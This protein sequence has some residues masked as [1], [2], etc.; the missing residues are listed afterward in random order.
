MA[1]QVL[2]HTATSWITSALGALQT[3]PS[4]QW[5]RWTAVILGIIIGQGL[6]Y[7]PSLLGSK[8]L[9]PLDILA[10]P[11]M[12]IPRTPVVA[13]IPE[14]DWSTGDLITQ[15]EPA[16]RYFASELR[17]G[18][19][20]GWANYHFAGAPF[21]WPRFSVFAL[22]NCLDESPRVLAWTQLIV[23]LVAGLGAYGFCREV[24]RL[25]FWPATMCGWCYPLTG[26]LVLWQGMWLGTSTV[27]WLP[28]LLLFVHQAI[29]NSERWKVPLGLIAV[30]FVTVTS[31]Q[32]DV[33]AQVMAISGLF[34]LWLVWHRK[35]AIILPSGKDKDG[36]ETTGPG[37]PR[38]EP[39]ASYVRP[40][41]FLSGGWALGLLLAAPY[42]L[43]F[44]EYAKTGYRIERRAQG[45]EERP[46]VGLA[47]L[48]QLVLPDYYGRSTYGSV[49]TI[50][51]VPQESAAGAYA[52]VVAMLVLSPVAWGSRRLRPITGFLWLLGLI[53]LS[54][55]LDLPV[56]VDAMRLPG[57]NLVSYNRLVFA[58]AFA[59]TVLA[60][61][62]LEVMSRADI[63]W[64]RWYW[65]GCVPILVAASACVYRW[66]APP[67]GIGPGLESL[68]QQGMTVSWIKDSAD[69]EQVRNWFAQH[70][71]VSAG[72][73]ILGIG[74]WLAFSFRRSWLHRAVP[75]LTIVLMG[76][77][78]WFAYGRASQS[79]WGLYYPRIE[80]LEQIKQAASGRVIGYHCLPATTAYMA[81]LQDIRGYD[82]VDP[83]RLIELLAQTADPKS[84]I[85]SYAYSQMLSPKVSVD[86]AGQMKLSPILDFLGV[87]YVIAREPFTN[88]LTT[89]FQS[90]DYYV[91]ENHRALPRVYVPGRFETEADPSLRLR[92]LTSE[93]FDPR[94]LVI[95]E[96][97][98]ELPETW[99]GKAKIQTT[100]STRITV[101]AQ[102]ESAGIVVLADL[103]DKGWQAQIDGHE[104]PILRVNHAIRG[105]VAPK[106][107]S[108][109]EFTYQPHSQFLGIRLAIAAGL[110][111]LAWGLITRHARCSGIAARTLA[112][113]PDREIPR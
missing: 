105:V 65:L 107:N 76:D 25:S 50:S 104:T 102:M 46:P 19:W 6:L 30:T 109:I 73:C 28:W 21:T 68:V 77:L 11:A 58:T 1:F 34:G 37:K 43:P 42:L 112:G 16:R 54:W 98:L 20:P 33:A 108:V 67:G 38:I 8:V 93:E 44:V 2:S 90:F 12:F 52:G 89:R 13:A 85:T 51:Q 56:V 32:L 83:A 14:H 79:D 53:G 71:A 113:R 110:G 18:R 72:F 66:F 70:Y 88:G 74:V 35:R 60:A 7:W 17:A 92:R 4:R 91:Y 81:G 69:I 15:G 5:Y 36:L 63:P 48:P 101:T 47:A 59:M 29:E 26:F 9:L 86:E 10:Q 55:Q 40:I 31:G 87:R 49:L 45:N 80:A 39:A 75:L 78:L 100:T 106:G 57:L 82:A 84:I 23:A 62:G 103:W 61:I 64:R 95:V 97:P 22:L 27:C 41:V 3:G 94:E 99:R 111:L 24:L 96:K